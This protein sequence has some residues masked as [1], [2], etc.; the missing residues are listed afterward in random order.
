MIIV[1]G[2][3]TKIKKRPTTFMEKSSM[4]SQKHLNF[5]TRCKNPNAAIPKS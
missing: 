3:V 2:N 5:D 4:V 1:E